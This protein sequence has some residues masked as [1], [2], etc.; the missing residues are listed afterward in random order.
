MVQPHRQTG[1][2]LPTGSG[3]E[4]WATDTRPESRWDSWDTVLGP[5]KTAKQRKEWREKEKE[6]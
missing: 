6:N 3:Q 4:S 2:Q 1:A 5:F